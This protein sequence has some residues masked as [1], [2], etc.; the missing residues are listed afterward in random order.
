M[1]PAGSCGASPQEWQYTD[2]LGDD[3]R[4]IVPIVSNPGLSGIGSL[5]RVQK[6][7][8]K[9]PS[10]KDGSGR[11]MCLSKWQ[12]HDTT[13][14]EL[15][16]WEHD[17]DYGYGFRTGHGGYIAVDCDIDDWDICSAVRQLLADALD[18]NWQIGRA[19]CRERV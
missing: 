6:T 8:G 17:P 9:I 15:T 2:A 18:V 5:L 13:A 12:V 14:A 7:R 11:V 3:I 16:A 10:V 4:Y 1:N 19:S